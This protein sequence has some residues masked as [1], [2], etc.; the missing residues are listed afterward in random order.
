MIWRELPTSTEAVQW[1]SEI[2]RDRP[3][4]PAFFVEA[5]RDTYGAT[6]QQVL[7][8]GLT[9]TIWPGGL[10]ITGD[11]GS[12][13]EPEAPILHQMFAILE[14]IDERRRVYRWE[15]LDEEERS[16]AHV[17]DEISTEVAGMR[18]VGP[19]GRVLVQSLGGTIRASI[20]IRRTLEGLEGRWI[21][22]EAMGTR[23]NQLMAAPTEDVR[24]RAGSGYHELSLYT[25]Q[26]LLRPAVVVIVDRIINQDGP[27]W[28]VVYVEPA[29]FGDDGLTLGPGAWYGDPGAAGI[30]DICQ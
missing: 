10:E 3:P 15:D 28:R 13:E 22:P 2:V 23:F 24:V 21:T 27:R 1:Y 16:P 18:A 14:S 4:P 17:I 11:R 29:T 12:T 6:A 9:A 5:P 25:E 30:G 7:Q 8:A 20:A 26:R 19:G